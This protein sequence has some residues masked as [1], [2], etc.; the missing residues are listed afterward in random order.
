MEIVKYNKVLHE[1][2][3]MQMLVEEGEDW[4]CYWKAAMNEKYREA[5]AK[6]LSYVAVEQSDVIGFSRS[7]DDCGIYI[8]V[9]DLLVKAEFRGKELGRQLMECIVKDHPERTV[10]VMSDVDPY[11][12]K[13]GYP[14]EGSVFEIK[15]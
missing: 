1:E 3:L 6:S 12:Q 13:L 4:S 9:C 2:K 5:L 14:R 10:Y 7:I 8:Y 15:L 11:Y